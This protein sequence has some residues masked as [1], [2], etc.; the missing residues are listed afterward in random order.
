MPETE[1]V[2][3]PRGRKISPSVFVLA[4]L[5]LLLHLLFDGRYGFFR[6]ELYYIACGHHLAWGYVDQPPL[7]AV[8]ARLSEALLGRSLYAIRFFPA[9]A[10]ATIVLLTGWLAAELGGDEFAQVLAAL[11]VLA[12]PAYLAFDSFLSMNAFEPIFWTLC[13]LILLRLV[14]GA[15]QRLWLLFGVIAG[16]G[17]LNKNSVLIFGYAVF[18]ALLATPARRFFYSRWIWIGALAAFAIFAPNLIWE[19]RHGWPQIHV[20]LN[21]DLYKN[22]PISPAEFLFQQILFMHP[23]ILPVWLGG[24]WYYFG[25]REGKPFRFLGIIYLVLLGVF[26]LLR[27]KTYY[28]LPAYP[29]LLAGGGVIWEKWLRQPGRRWMRAGLATLVV[30]GG[31]ITLPYGV[32]VLSVRHFIRYETLIPIG[33]DVRMERDSRAILPQL[34]G[35]MF[36]WRHITA[37]VAKVY[38]AVPLPQRSSC[39]ILAS[40]YGEAGAIDYYGRRYGLPR[41]ISGHNNYYL[42]GPRG[43][44]GACVIAIGVAAS[45]LHELFGQVKLETLVMNR[46]SMPVENHLPIYLCGDPKAALTKMWPKLR[47]YI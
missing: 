24:L 28:L 32:P 2:P 17:L 21:A 12:A 46:Y 5:T 11:A 25:T 42:W 16:I 23:L 27:S 3:A 35:D 38:D 9:L 8:F 22:V 47:Y 10:G 40:N 20:V 15:D 31:I 4:G 34:Y 6:D 45:Q 7:V 26:L 30:I 37:S 18:V 29:L 13:A 1:L 41:A 36:G 19:W 43:Y 14:K 44:S 33:H 39:A